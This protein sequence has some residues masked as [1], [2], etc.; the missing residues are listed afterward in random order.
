M[1]YSIITV[2]YNNKAGLRKTIESVIHQS[3]S[4]F[5]F[6]VIDGGS[7]DG[8]A[9]VLKEYD[10]QISYWVSEPD[11]GIYQGMNKGIAKATGEYLIFMNSGD[12]FYNLNV[13]QNVANMDLYQDVIIGRD[14]HFNSLTK[15]G[16]ATILPKRIS[17]ITLF[18]QALPHQSTFYKRI[19]FK[20]SL[21]DESL[22]L[23]ADH[24]FNIQK[25]CLED[26][27]IS[28]IDKII[29]F[30]EPGGASD[31]NRE[32]SKQ[33]SEEVF[34]QL[35]PIGVIK[36]YKTLSCLDKSTVYKLLYEC[37]NQKARKLLTFCIKA[38][39]R[40]IRCSNQ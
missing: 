21:Y 23:V 10:A 35:L 36:D 19:L 18:M 33:E 6:I 15:K 3:F 9:E 38:I 17:M 29:C 31:K 26:R 16:F 8:S 34:K 4:D 28:I 14:Y 24:K 27:S 2:N 40:L 25:L 1:K 12:R 13:L 37:E 32:L 20:N 22:K 39:Y 30:R 11:S 5:E 7:T